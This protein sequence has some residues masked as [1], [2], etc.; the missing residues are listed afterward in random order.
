M[1]SAPSVFY[2]VERS[3]GAASVLAAAWLCAVA[4]HVLWWLAQAANAGAQAAGLLALLLSAALA[5]HSWRSLQPG[6]LAWDGDGW[7]WAEAGR[8]P[9]PGWRLDVGLDLQRAL[10]LR[11]RDAGGVTRWLWLER[12]ADP[13][14]W[15]DLRRAVCAH[16]AGGAGPRTSRPGR[17]GGLSAGG[18]R[19]AP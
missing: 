18:P 5:V 2:P 16:R 7:H 9:S 3:R 13:A 15:D 10:L 19:A 1:H 14:R 8:G 11:L 12:S 17:T 6:H 4:A